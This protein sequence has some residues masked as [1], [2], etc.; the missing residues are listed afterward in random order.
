MPPGS[1]PTSNSAFE[2]MPGLLF[3]WLSPKEPR[4]PDRCQLPESKNPLLLLGELGIPVLC[5]VLLWVGTRRGPPLVV[6][7]EGEPLALVNPDLGLAQPTVPLVV[8]L[9]PLALPDARKGFCPIP[10]PVIS[11]REDSNEALIGKSGCPP[12]VSIPG[13]ESM[14]PYFSLMWDR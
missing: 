7:L 14:M 13:Y 11:G 6:G 2:A 1:T 10:R 9:E 12:I 8:G 5:I 3:L 4:S